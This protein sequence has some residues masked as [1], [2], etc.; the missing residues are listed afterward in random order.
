[1]SNVRL[2]WTLPTVSPRQRAIQHTRI[3]FR[4]D[5]SFPWTQQDVVSPD[6]NQEL[7]FQDV[8]PGT[9]FYRGTV[10]D[11]D[12]REGLPAFTQVDVPFDA[13]GTVS[14]FTATVE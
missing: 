7:L 11:V 14:N 3:D 4:V 6:V 5:P 10:V 12:G 13:P 2:T 8:A 1:M 9:H